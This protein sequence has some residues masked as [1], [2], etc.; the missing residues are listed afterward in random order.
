MFRLEYLGFALPLAAVAAPLIIWRL[1]RKALAVRVPAGR[2]PT[3]MECDALR[4]HG[5]L[6][7][8][9]FVLFWVVSLVM[10]FAATLLNAP[11]TVE[12]A[13][14]ALIFLMVAGGAAFQLTARCPICQYRLSYQRTLGVP[15]RCE[16]CGAN[17]QPPNDSVA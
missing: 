16:R 6:S 13:V 14:L 15:D 8:I 12:W 9:G 10:V 3:A 1:R 2:Q 7:V 5:R 4:A 17:L 11:D